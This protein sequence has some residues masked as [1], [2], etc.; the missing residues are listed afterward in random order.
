MTFPRSVE[1]YKD[2]KYQIN[3]FNN[4]AILGVDCYICGEIG[5]ISIDCHEF[6][7]IEGNLRLHALDKLKTL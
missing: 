5:H 4:L 2:I 3:E 7:S 1:L 6:K